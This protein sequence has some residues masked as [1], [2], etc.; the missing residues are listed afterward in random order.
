[1]MLSNMRNF[2]FGW[3]IFLPVTVVMAQTNPEPCATMIQDKILGAKFPE[4][5]TID[6]FEGAIQQKIEEIRAMKA[7]GRT[8]AS[9]I[10]LPIIVHIIH[11][12]EAVGTGT[13][14]SAA[15][16]Q[17]QIEVLNED[18]RKMLG[19]PGGASS[20]PIAADIEIE[21]CLS[22]LDNNGAPMAEPGIHRQQGQ[23]SAWTRDEIES[24]LKP[25]TIWNPSSFYNIWTVKF[26]PAD[27]NL[28][29]Y[30]QFPDQTGLSGIPETSTPSAALT[31]GVVIR[32]Q[33]FGSVDKGTF[34]VMVAPY[35][36]GRTLT[37]ET[38][39]WLGL[40][41]IWGDG[42]C[43]D[44]FVSD[45]PTAQSASSGCNVG[46][47]SCSNTNMVENYMDYSDDACMNIFTEGQKTRMLAAVAASPRRKA[48][49]EQGCPSTVTEVPTASFTTDKLVC[50]LLGSDVT[51]SDL[52]SNFPKGWYWKF[53]GGNP[54][55]STER[56][57][58]VQYDT[59]GSYDVWLVAKNQIGNSDTIKKANFIVVSDQGLCAGVS[60][61]KPGYT[62]TVLNLSAFGAYTGF[63]TGHNSKGDKGFS[64]FFDNK[65]G[66]KY[67]S[68]ASVQFAN[69]SSLSE[70]AKIYITVWNARGSQNGPGSV[71]ERKEVLLKQI[72]EDV[73]NNR[74]TT[75]SFDR[76]TPLFSR[77]FHVGVEIKYNEGYT[78]AVKSS[79]NGQATDATSWVMDANGE[80][81]LMTIA[82]GANIAMDIQPI[83]GI[84]LSVQVS[85]SDVLVYPGQKVV[86]NGR[87]ASIFEWSSS[88]GEIENYTGPQLIVRPTETTT[89]TTKGS[90][91]QLC[92][93]TT[94]TT[95]YVRDNVVG[96]EDELLQKEIT[97]HPNP[98]SNFINVAV[99]NDYTGPVEVNVYSLMG[100]PVTQPVKV[101][102]S[103]RFLNVTVPAEHLNSGMYVVK[104]I[105]NRKQISKK[106]VHR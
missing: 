57:P 67:I 38:G 66:Y 10:S 31:D 50:V 71:V 79:A 6:D 17:S 54:S 103:E 81:K 20:N 32:Y 97:V 18:F 92:A 46:R 82:Y 9:V 30:A 64:E 47:F 95:V 100:S 7:A 42:P 91:L 12:G 43:A 87:G 23:L 70:D 80:W 52:S 4:R 98:G 44:D 22:Q 106:W 5:G 19:T 65:C 55:T 78:L 29:G 41:H 21:F 94:Y 37:H 72:L 86:L 26:A 8:T 48:L 104:I 35:N 99:D 74:P 58:V 96:L 49:A 76:E 25:N 39:H 83:I 34:P 24:Q 75:I 60:N 69:V 45:T 102:K 62:S 16:V 101:N 85:A 59:P 84:Y 56:Y 15:Q 13:N 77:A 88:D 11:N 93:D 2:L 28:I 1:M 36:K 90:G 89:Y 53:E 33:S 51:F 68:G 61:F 27:A 40:R 63:L 73:A 3:F 14:L 105:L